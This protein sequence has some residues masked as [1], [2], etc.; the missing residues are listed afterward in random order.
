[1]I[2]L[3][4]STPVATPDFIIAGAAKCGT[5]AL[6]HYLD[7]H[8]E[9]GMTYIKEPRFF[10]EAKGGMAHGVV[11]AAIPRSGTYHRARRGAAG[12][13]GRPSPGR[14]RKASGKETLAP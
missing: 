12:S 3:T 9:V 11:D 8:P 6:W 10:T 2:T 7:A 1:M 13:P 4:Q 5:T 14:R